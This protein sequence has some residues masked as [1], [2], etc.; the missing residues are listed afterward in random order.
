MN[1]DELIDE[2]R[3]VGLTKYESQAYVAAVRL[4]SGRPNEL[5]DS[6]GV[7]QARIYD[8]IDDLR[9][10]GLVEVQERSQGKEVHAPPPS[11]V[12]DELRQRHIAELTDRI[13]AVS[14]SLADLH[15]YE[16]TSEGF[17]TMVSLRESAL[18]HVKQAIDD[19]EWWLTMALPVDVYDAV[20]DNIAD[21]TDRGVTVRIVVDGDEARSA[22]PRPGRMGPSF[23]EDVAVRHRPSLDTFAFADRTY[24]I[25]NSKHPQAESQP[26][27]ITQERNLVLLFQM[28]AEQVWTGSKTIQTGGGLPKRYLDPWRA[29]VDLRDGLDADTT[30][31]AEVDGRETHTRSP[32]TWTG[33]VVDYEIGGPVGGSFDAVAP[34][35]ASL[36]LDT[37]DDELTVGGW[38]ATIEDIAADGLQVDEA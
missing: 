6:S 16:Q 25:F 17:V 13:D 7:P 24:G 21:A 10:M 9:E 38:K 32:G 22:D 5:A 33:E 27:I 36:T 2:L 14:S 11:V 19:A 34:T 23:P 4:G 18:R 31:V 28:Y 20:A 3:E 1:E 8:V 35:T 26:Y 12:L 29:I 30:F 37:D 15:N